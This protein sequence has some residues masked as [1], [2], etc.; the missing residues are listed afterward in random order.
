MLLE[1][2]YGGWESD[3]PKIE[4]PR[5]PAKEGKGGKDGGKVRGLH[6]A[7]RGSVKKKDARGVGGGGKGLEEGGGGARMVPL[8]SGKQGGGHSVV[9]GVDL[10]VAPGEFVVLTGPV[11]CGKSTLLSL[12]GLF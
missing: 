2:V 3:A 10:R 12:A 11:G 6:A 4:L 8:G 1:D 5:A 9:R 7:G